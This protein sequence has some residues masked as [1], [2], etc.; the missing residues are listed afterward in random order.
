MEPAGGFCWLDLAATDAARARAFYAEVFGWSS[1]VQPA[2]GGRFVRLQANGRDVGSLYQ[3]REAQLAQGTPSH[4]TPYVGVDDVER[5]AERAGASGGA[6]LVR[7][8]EV[9]GVAR[10][11]LIR[12][13]V[14]A[15]V[16]L[17]QDLPRHA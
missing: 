15:L 9:D 10:I 4:W 16:G 6:V 13:A 12:D 8:F 7:P 1:G 5:V 11:A 17:W 3:L 2:N 14:G